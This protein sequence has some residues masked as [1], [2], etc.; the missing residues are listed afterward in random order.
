[1]HL[2]KLKEAGQPTESRESSPTKKNERD[3]AEEFPVGLNRADFY[4]IFLVMLH[5][6]FYAKPCDIK[7]LNPEAQI[8][9]KDLES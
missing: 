7:S 1:M 2:I 3:A 9:E 8:K 6:R 5:T 4:I